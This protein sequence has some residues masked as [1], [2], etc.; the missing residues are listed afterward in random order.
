MAIKLTAAALAIC[1]ANYTKNCGGCPL[2]P[3]CVG[4][5][6][7]GQEALDRWTTRINERAEELNS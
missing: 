2:R 5:I 7:P 4:S 6:G 1:E 3:E